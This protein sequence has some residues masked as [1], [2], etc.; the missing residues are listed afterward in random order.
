MQYLSK[1]T[2]NQSQ[3]D[4]HIES[5]LPQPLRTAGAWSWR[6]IVIAVALSGLVWISGQFS[7]III[8]LMVALLIAVVAEPVAAKMRNA[9]GF[10][11]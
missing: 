5:G 7:T 1:N 9:W 2:Q 11:R 4:K 10:P 3:A 8:A 6:V